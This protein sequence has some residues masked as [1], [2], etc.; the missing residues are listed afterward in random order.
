MSPEIGESQGHARRRA[1]PTIRLTLVFCNRGLEQ[2]T[3]A[4]RQALLVVQLRGQMGCHACY[5]SLRRSS[6]RVR[7]RRIES[8]MSPPLRTRRDFSW[9]SMSQGPSSRFAS[10]EGERVSLG[11]GLEERDLQRPLADGVV[12]AY[13]LVQPTLA[14]NTVTFRVDVGAA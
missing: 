7:S 8:A 5:P 4:M 3:A 1:R 13:E 12:L 11:A 9:P 10:P 14:E 6:R 2:P